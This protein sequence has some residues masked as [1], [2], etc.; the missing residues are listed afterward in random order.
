MSDAQFLN[1]RRHRDDGELR[2]HGK[3]SE[4]VEG[5]FAAGG[6]SACEVL[7]LAGIVL[8]WN[9]GGCALILIGRG[10]HV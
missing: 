3:D 9:C 10:A 6:A 2:R 7:A 5:A 4:S 1:Q 8:P